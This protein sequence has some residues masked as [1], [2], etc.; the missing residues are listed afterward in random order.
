MRSVDFMEVPGFSKRGLIARL[1]AKGIS[2]CETPAKRR[3]NR[4]RYGRGLLPPS[5][6]QLGLYGLSGLVLLRTPVVS[7]AKR[8]NSGG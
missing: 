2:R 5:R 8:V 1:T 7:G 4:G 3:G 6:A